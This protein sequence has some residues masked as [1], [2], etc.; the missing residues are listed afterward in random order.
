M[1]R[2]RYRRGCAT[3]VLLR[4]YFPGYFPICKAVA[5]VMK[6]QL[7][8]CQRCIFQTGGLFHCWLFVSRF[9]L[10]E[11]VRF[12]GCVLPGESC[13]SGFGILYFRLVKLLQLLQA[14]FLIE[15]FSP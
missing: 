5:Q 7:R 6:R 12:E 1:A 3:I 15:Q 10:P 11:R 9:I 13:S 8:S 2:C 14:V 4:R